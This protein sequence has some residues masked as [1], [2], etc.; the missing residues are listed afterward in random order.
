MTLNFH[1]PFQYSQLE[2]QKDVKK[3]GI[4]I[5]GF[6]DNNVE[7]WDQASDYFSQTFIPYYVGKSESSVYKKVTEHFST[8][9]GDISTNTIL[10]LN[11]YENLPAFFGK[12]KRN[13]VHNESLMKQLKYVAYF[14]N[15]SFILRK[16]K[17][18]VEENT[19]SFKID[20][21]N[22]NKKIK[23]IIDKI[24]TPEN[25][26]ICYAPLKSRSM[27]TFELA[28]IAVRFC[29]KGNTFCTSENTLSV[30]QY[31]NVLFDITCSDSRGQAECF[32][33]IFYSQS[34]N[35]ETSSHNIIFDLK[36]NIYYGYKSHDFGPIDWYK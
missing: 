16:Y 12:L 17:H 13:A 1:G 30:L 34:Y 18:K 31:S 32:F 25:L 29:L 9:Y 14:N 7:H 3:P 15:P 26:C 19:S 22:Q 33:N 8:I 6:M 2:R 35:G 20:H 28:E 23:N 21:L 11:A 10:E 4:F 27:N 24:F 36:S 5:L